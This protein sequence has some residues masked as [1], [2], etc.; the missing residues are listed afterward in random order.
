MVASIKT[1]P[2][3]SMHLVA[4]LLVAALTFTAVLA[5]RAAADTTVTVKP[6]NLQGWSF[7]DDNGYG[8]TYGMV[9]G[10]GTAPLG[11]GSA[12]LAVSD[13]L[14]GVALGVHSYQ[15]TRLDQI[16][17]LKYSTYRVSGGSALAIALS[18]DIDYDVTDTNTSYQGRLTFEP[19]YTNTVLTG[20]WQAWDTLTAAGT[21]NW[22]ATASPGTIYCPIGNPCTWGQVLAYYPNAGM[23]NPGALLLK[24]GSGWASFQG[25]ADKLIVGVSGS[26]TTFDFE[27]DK[28]TP[29]P[30]PGP[31][32]VGGVS[33]DSAIGALP[34]DATDA[35]GSSAA[36]T[37]AIAGVAAGAA[38]LLAAAWYTARRRRPQPRR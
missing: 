5:G 7:F 15:G 36:R 3:R 31:A 22:W 38:A 19:Y 37:G 29:T 8:G 12:N 4:L 34:S 27:P 13:S 35:S 32:P 9:V 23:R 20:T 6:S 10:P 16:T 21:G 26:S 25:S 24:A 1:R 2:F 17:E 28:V 11:K 18:F 30:P 33:V 14:Q